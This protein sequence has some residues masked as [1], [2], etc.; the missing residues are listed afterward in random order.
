MTNYQKL[1]QRIIEEVGGKANVSSATHCMTRLRLVLKDE[2]LADD[3]KLNAIPEVISVV[4]A[5]GQVQLVIGPTVDKVY[6]A[7]CREGG[8]EVQTAIDEDL[9]AAERLP[10]K[11]RFAPKRI[12]NLILDA[13]SGSIAP[14]LPVFCIAGIFR[15]FTILLGPEGAGLLAAEGSMYRL[16]TL[17]GDAAYYFLPIFG[18]Y[19]A[20]K[21]FQ[22]SPV[23]ALMTAAIM[24]HPSMLAIV[25]E[26]A[27]FDVYGIPMTLVNY[28][29]SVLPIILIVWIQSYVEGLIKKHCP[30]ML[31]ILVIPVGTMLI[32][33]PLALCVFG[34]AVSFIMGIIA[35]I[36]IWLGANAGPL[37]GLVVGATW[38]LVI[39]TGMHVP[40]LTA[41]MPGWLEVGYDA[42]C[43]PGTTVVVYVTL[44][45]ALAYGIRAKGKAN[46]QLGWTTFATYALGRVSEPIIYGILLRDKKALA[47]SMIGGAAGGLACGLLDARIFVFS[48]VGFPWMNVIKFSQDIIP[49][50]ISCAIGFAVTF[51]LCMVFGFD[52]RES[53]EKE[54]EEA[55]EA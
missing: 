38:N 11:E 37:C 30:D 13:V 32:M 47:W 20:A 15:M 19:A 51:A 14:I 10:W 25:E 6:G 22:T 44:A 55:L 35:D 27:P 34:P 18:A 46:R 16:F 21:K 28:T 52:N 29:Q 45:V 8:F 53:G 2:G 1:A 9:D 48:G 12:G 24:I 26:G 42:V 41:M 49:G 31:R 5:G 50:A 40:I 54:A 23:L 4:H 36:I 33:L 3:A 43:T 39:A 7:V 17:V